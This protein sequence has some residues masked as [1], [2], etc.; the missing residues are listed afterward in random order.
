MGYLLHR[1]VAISTR[2]ALLWGL[3][4]LLGSAILGW[5]FFV[6]PTSLVGYTWGSVTLLTQTIYALLMLVSLA[7]SMVVV[8]LMYS[9]KVGVGEL[10]GRMLYAHAPITLLMLPAIIGDKVA[11]SIFM[12]NP[13]NTQLSTLYVVLMVLFVAFILV[14]YIYWS[15]IAFSRSVN[16]KGWR[17]I[18]VFGVAMMLSYILSKEMLSW[19]IYYI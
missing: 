4:W 13:F 12:V 8:A 11:Y 6:V 3:F 1:P 16:R 15:Y 14:W 19:T 17:V 5:H 7:L 2:N 18:A 10:V 9:P